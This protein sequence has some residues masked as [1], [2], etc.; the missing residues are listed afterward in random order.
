MLSDDRRY[1]VP[2]TLISTT[3][4]REEIDRYTAAGEA[5]FAE[6]PMIADV[7]IVEVPTGHW[8]QFTK[9]EQLA[10]VIRDSLA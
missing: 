10:K 9:A 3:F 8:P 1:A 4:T 7:T 5:Y 2:V 6:L